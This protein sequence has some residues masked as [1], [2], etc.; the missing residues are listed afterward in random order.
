M[1]HSRCVPKEK[2]FAWAETFELNKIS[3]N[4]KKQKLVILTIKIWLVFK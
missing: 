2:R 4:R 3:P 1:D